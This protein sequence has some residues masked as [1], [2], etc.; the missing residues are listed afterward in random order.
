MF[1][2]ELPLDQAEGAILA[3][4]YRSAKG[5]GKIRKGERLTKPLMA[6][7]QADGVTRV[8]VARLDDD[9]L[10]EN[11]AA[12]VI[13]TALAGENTRLGQAATG[14]VNIHAVCDGL[15]AISKQVIHAINCIDE[16]ITV[17]TLSPAARVAAGQ[18]VATIKIITYA[19]ASSNVDKAVAEAGNSLIVHSFCGAKACLIQTKVSTTKDSVLDK[20]RTTTENRLLER[21]AILILEQRTAHSVSDLCAAL[22][23]AQSQTPDWILI[24]GASATSDRNDVVPAA[25]VQSG[26]SL[27]HFGMPVDPGN[28]FLLGNLGNSI[29]IGMP[30]CARS[31]KFNGVDKV[32]DK[33]SCGLPVTRDWIAGLGVGGLLQEIVDRPRPRVVA[34]EQSSVS[35]LLLGAGSSSRYGEANKLLVQWQGLPLIQ[36]VLQTIAE[37]DVSN[38]LLVTGHEAGLVKNLLASIA[39]VQ[40]LRLLHNNAYSTGMASSLIKGVSALIDSDAII[41]C[42]GDMPV[43]SSTVINELLDAFKKHPD[44]ALY[45]PTYEGRR[46]NPVLIARQL[47]DS[48]LN[49]EGDTGARVLAKQFPDTVMEVPTDCAG[50]LQD[51]DTPVDLDSLSV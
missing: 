39:G 29:V 46:G 19:A 8:T 17:A 41:V 15:L 5:Q 16:S 28:L 49:L 10:H 42:L 12:L 24:F 48:V 14:R 30:G 43:V 2:G 40:G 25:I 13:A 37:S 6:I 1:F 38:I 31:R 11:Q 23:H 26:G 20:T 21:Q 34:R 45:I 9:D 27:V 36:H 4:S 44:K 47:Y 32:L 51:V 33:L 22:E 50:I 3:H 18:I 35:A 7:L